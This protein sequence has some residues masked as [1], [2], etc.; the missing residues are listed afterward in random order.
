MLGAG[1]LQTAISIHLN[2]APNLFQ[3]SVWT[4]PSLVLCVPVMC[5]FWGWHGTR[6]HHW[7]GIGTWAW[8]SLRSS[9]PVHSYSNPPSPSHSPISSPPSPQATLRDQSV[10]VTNEFG[11]SLVPWRHY[12]LTHLDGYMCTMPSGYEHSLVWTLP[13][14]HR[15]GLEL[16]VSAYEIV[17]IILYNTYMHAASASGQYGEQHINILVIVLYTGV[18]K[19]CVQYYTLVEISSSFMQPH[20]QVSPT[21]LSA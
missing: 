6:P 2:L 16:T 7:Y 15:W 21:I 20:V 19:S 10:N 13:P 8:N 11:S 3:S 9:L 12:R 17:A 5:T 1:S 18:K 14:Q 4:H